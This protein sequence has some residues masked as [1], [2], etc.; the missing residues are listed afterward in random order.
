MDPWK[1]EA[2]KVSPDWIA[3]PRINICNTVNMYIYKGW[4]LDVDRHYMKTLKH[5]EENVSTQNKLRK[6]KKPSNSMCQQATMT[7]PC[8]APLTKYRPENSVTLVHTFL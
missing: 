7:L 4:A 1:P 3:P 2:S 5:L 6:V 8:H